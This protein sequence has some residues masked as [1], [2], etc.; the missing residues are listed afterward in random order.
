MYSKLLY[1]A[2]EFVVSVITRFNLF[3]LVNI[4]KIYKINSIN[5][6]SYPQ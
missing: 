6:M 3:V 5:M 2:P 1:K 4:D